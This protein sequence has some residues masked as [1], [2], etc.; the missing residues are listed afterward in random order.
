VNTSFIE[1]ARACLANG[2]RLLCDAKFLSDP[3]Q[4]FFEDADVPWKP[5]SLALAMLA[6]EEFAKGFLLFL[7]GQGIIPWSNGV[8]HAARDHSS[9]H[10]LSALME[11]ARYRGNDCFGPEVSGHT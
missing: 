3:N 10:L 8:K 11:Y 9:K 7:V 2:E 5:R 6:E 1:T 4:R